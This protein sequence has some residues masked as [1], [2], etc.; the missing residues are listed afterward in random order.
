LGGGAAQM[1]WLVSIVGPGGE[2]D[3]LSKVSI[4]PPKKRQKLV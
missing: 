4:P 1:S 2:Y 3:A